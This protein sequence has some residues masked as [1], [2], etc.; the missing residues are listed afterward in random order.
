MDGMAVRQPASAL[1]Y[2]SPWP[3]RDVMSIIFHLMVRAAC[4]SAVTDFITAEEVAKKMGARGVVLEPQWAVSTREGAVVMKEEEEAEEAEVDTM[5]AE[6]GTIL[7]ALDPHIYRS[8]S[9]QTHKAAAP[10]AL[11]VTDCPPII[12]T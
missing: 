7:V 12:S 5:G 3:F 1:L 11:L 6:E 10:V 9:F 4:R 2:S 8:L